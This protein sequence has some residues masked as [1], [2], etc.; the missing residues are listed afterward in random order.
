MNK[1]MVTKIGFELVAFSGEAKSQL[2][3]ALAE[4]KEGNFKQAETLVKRAQKTL[5]KAHNIQTDLL[6]QDMDSSSMEFNLLLVHGQDHLMTTVL[7]QD[8]VEHFIELYKR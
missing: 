5:V 1:E 4:A 2:L 8:L 7:L 6:V 3:I